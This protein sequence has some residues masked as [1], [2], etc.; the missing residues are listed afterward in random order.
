MDE[1]HPVKMRLHD[2]IAA[3]DRQDTRSAI[4]ATALAFAWLASAAEAPPPRPAQA[5]REGMHA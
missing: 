3:M 2:A 1:I 5:S 4:V